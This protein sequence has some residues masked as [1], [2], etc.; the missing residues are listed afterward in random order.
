MID[1]YKDPRI[2]HLCVRRDMREIKRGP[3]LLCSSCKGGNYVF[4]E[5]SEI[6]EINEIIYEKYTTPEAKKRHRKYR[7]TGESFGI[8]EFEVTPDIVERPDWVIFKE[9]DNVLYGYFTIPSKRNKELTLNFKR[10]NEKL[11]GNS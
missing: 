5:E 2:A 1:I 10:F 3:A 7:A 11:N 9:F 8:Y 6:N 4:M